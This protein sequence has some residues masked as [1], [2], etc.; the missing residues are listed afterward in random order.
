MTA[1]SNGS[2]LA[3]AMPAASASGVGS[4]TSTPVTP[5]MTVS[6]APPR[7]E[8]NDGRA[9]G[10]RLDRR[11]AEI[12]FARKQHRGR[13]AIVIAHV[14]VGERSEQLHVGAGRA[15]RARP[16]RRAPARCR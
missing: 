1:R 3:R 12:F 6:S 5:S 14:L 8:R 4:S 7:A 15:R 16:K 2:C 10:L 11:D 9:A 13:A